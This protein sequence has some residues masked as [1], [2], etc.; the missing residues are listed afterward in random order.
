L[1]NSRHALFTTKKAA[2]LTYI[3]QQLLRTLPAIERELYPPSED[4]PAQTIVVDVTRPN[5]QHQA[6]PH[7]ALP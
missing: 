7:D 5:R 2:A 6:S 3:L 4:G 1:A